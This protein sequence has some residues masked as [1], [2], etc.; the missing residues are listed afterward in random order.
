MPARLVVGGLLVAGTF[1]LGQPAQASTC[2]PEFQQVCYTV[3]T[4]T[5]ATYKVCSLIR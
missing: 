2:S 3:C 1:A 5:Y 4:S